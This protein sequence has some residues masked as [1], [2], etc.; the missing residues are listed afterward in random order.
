[1]V[2]KVTVADRAAVA[3]FAGAVKVTDRLPVPV[4][5]VAVTQ[6]AFEDT[7]TDVFDVTATAV[8]PPATGAVQDDAEMVNVGATYPG[9]V[10]V[11]VRVTTG[12]PELVEKISVAD[13]AVVEVFACAVKVTDLLPVPVAG[14]TLTHAAFD[15]TDTDVF[16]V[17]A[18]AAEPPATGAAHAD[19]EMVNAGGCGAAPTWETTR[20]RV[21][22]GVPAVDVKVSVAVRAVVAVFA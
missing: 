10:T 3:V 14:D 8:E 2:V 11:N 6:A 5:G 18:T 13:R 12:V 16:D 19:A 21:T 22:A 7:V 20:V 17:T 15:D 4:A 9:C 1:V